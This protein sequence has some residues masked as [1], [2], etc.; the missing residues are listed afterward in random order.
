[1]KIAFEFLKPVYKADKHVFDR[2]GGTDIDGKK[3]KQSTPG[4]R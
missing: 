4:R 3:G 1:M 2:G